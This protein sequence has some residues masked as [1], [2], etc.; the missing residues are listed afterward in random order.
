MTLI[1]KGTKYLFNSLT[2]SNFN[3]SE[4]RLALTYLDLAK[5]SSG[6]SSETHYLKNA[7]KS[8]LKSLHSI[9]RNQP[10]QTYLTYKHL[11]IISKMLGRDER[12]IDD[13]AEKCMKYFKKYGEKIVSE[14]E[15]RMSMLSAG[16]DPS[17]LMQECQALATKAEA[18]NNDDTPAIC[19]K[20]H[21]TKSFKT[22]YQLDTKRYDTTSCVIL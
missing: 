1:T 18:Y 8:F 2:K 14:G 10:E 12:V 20:L 3:D 21:R 19:G 16:E 22:G 11:L 17:L 15:M 4:N 13:Y 6:H 7:E 5:K 9:R